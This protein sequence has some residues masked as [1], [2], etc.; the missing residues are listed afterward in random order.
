V[1]AGGVDGSVVMSTIASG[2]PV[3]QVKEHGDSIEGVAF[4]RGLPLVVSASMDGQVIIWDT[5]AGSKR[6]VCEHPDG[7]VALAMQHR[8]ALFATAC[9]DGVVRVFDVRTAQL[10]TALRRHQD[11]VQAIAWAPDDVHL[12]SGSDDHSVCIYAVTL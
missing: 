12:L 8:G 10:V 6:G 9:I 7:V 2:K 11:T 4:A 1:V 5:S 3:A